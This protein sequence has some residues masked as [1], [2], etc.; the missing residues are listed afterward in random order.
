MSESTRAD[1]ASPTRS[2]FQ[3]TTTRT[4][5]RSSWLFTVFFIIVLPVVVAAVLFRLDPF[6]PVHF[7]AHE[8]SRSTF[9]GPVARNDRMRRG[10]EV[11][12]EGHVAGPEDLAYDA[13]TRV[14]YTGCE[15][16]WIKRVTLNDSVGDS[17]VED[18]VNTGGRPLGLVFDKNGA[19]IVADAHKVSPRMNL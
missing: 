5:T 12:A 3:S 17:V 2:E 11:V 9:T 10:S 18:W 6:Q 16:G 15:D 19:L 1:S 8:M 14:V 4:G 7:P 13:T